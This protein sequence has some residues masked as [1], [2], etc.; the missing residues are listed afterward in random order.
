MSVKA[1]K[2]F[3]S[4]ENNKILKKIKKANKFLPEFSLE[5]FIVLVAEPRRRGTIKR[6]SD[7]RFEEAQRKQGAPRLFEEYGVEGVHKSSR[8]LQKEATDKMLANY[9]P[10]CL[11]KRKRS[12]R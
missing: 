2:K 6:Y 7:A 4:R 3:V 1:A 9:H 5:N 12:A 11:M 10:R 8:Q